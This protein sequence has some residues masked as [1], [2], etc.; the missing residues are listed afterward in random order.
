ADCAACCAAADA[1]P[2]DGLA[3]RLRQAWGAR[4]EEAPPWPREVVT[5][6]GPGDRLGEYRLLRE[7][8]RGGMGVVYEAVQESLGRHVA[9]KM[10]PVHAMYDPRFLQRFQREARAAGRLLHAH[11]VPVYGVGEHAG[12]HYYVMQYI[13]GRGLDDLLAELRRT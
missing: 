7:I 9:L 3:T 11:I 4:R 5:P 13:A 12:V 8:G 6:S 1:L 2:D 10:L